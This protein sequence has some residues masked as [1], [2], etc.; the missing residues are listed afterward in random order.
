MSDSDLP[1][2]NAFEYPS[3]VSL[4]VV[5]AVI[6]Q[7]NQIFAAK[8]K[9]GGGSGLKWEFPGGKIELGETPKEAL[10]REIY[11]EL[12]IDVSVGKCLGTFI[13]PLDKYLIH[14][15]CFWCTT[16]QMDVTLSSHTETG[17]FSAQELLDLDWALPDVPALNLVL[18]AMNACNDT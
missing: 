7:S 9:E 10:Q 12:S 1:T 15:Q 14:L 17:W 2:S 8:R 11:E 16:E 4:R 13:T 6:R 5:A 18:K 3:L